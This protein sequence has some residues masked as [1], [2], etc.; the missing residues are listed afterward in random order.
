M[1]PAVEVDHVHVAHADAAGG[2]VAAD[3]GGLVG[4]VNAD[5]RVFVALEEI[6][7][8]GA[9]RIVPAALERPVLLIDLE[10]RPALH[11][12]GCRH[13]GRPFLHRAD[14]GAAGPSHIFGPA[15][16]P[17]L[18]R[19]AMGQHIIEIVVAGIDDDRARLLVGLIRDFV[20]L[21]VGMRYSSG[22]ASAIICLSRA[23]SVGSGRPDW[24]TDWQPLVRAARPSATPTNPAFVFMP[25]PNRLNR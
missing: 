25:T 8:A 16:D 6:E 5:E 3:L 17:V 24:M 20:A 19:L 11:D 23:L 9:E 14:G 18:D 10:L 4:P 7:R 12:R 2:H 1:D 21:T 22:S 13:P 15:R